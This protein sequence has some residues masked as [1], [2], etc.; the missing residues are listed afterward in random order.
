MLILPAALA[1]AL[2]LF[3]QP[4]H[5]TRRPSATKFWAVDVSCGAGSISSPVLSEHPKNVSEVAL[6]SERIFGTIANNAPPWLLVSMFSIASR[7]MVTR[8]VQDNIVPALIS[9]ED[10]QP[11]ALELSQRV[12][13][14]FDSKVQRLLRPAGYKNTE[15][16]L[17]RVIDGEINDVKQIRSVDDLELTR[18]VL[19]LA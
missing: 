19:E 7:E 12:R 8:Q 1:V 13:R 15:T 6:L 11:K 17:R 4:S 16:V 14:N 10:A 3:G 18:A 5:L 9:S 2:H